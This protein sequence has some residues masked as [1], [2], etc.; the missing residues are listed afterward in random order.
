M[1]GLFDPP[2][3]GVRREVDRGWAHSIAHPW[4]PISSPLT[5][6][7]YLVPFL[8]YLAGSKSVS[9]RPSDPDTMTN[10]ALKAFASSNSKN[11]TDKPEIFPSDLFVC[12]ANWV[13]EY[14]LLKVSVAAFVIGIL[15]VEN[16][17]AEAT[18]IPP[19]IIETIPSQIYY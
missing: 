5:H 18:V 17:V 1:G 6:I 2:V 12:H 7:V 11:R 15:K 14:G 10:T 16:Q 19:T 9:T 8:S 4:V 3:W 13:V